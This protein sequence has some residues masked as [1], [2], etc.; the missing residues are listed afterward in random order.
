MSNE[1]RRV[2]LEDICEYIRNGANIK[3]SDNA[4]GTP[5][6][7]IETLSNGK[8]NRDRLGYA[9]IFDDK[10]SKYYLNNHD[11]L[12]SHI[13]SEKYLGRAVLYTKESKNEKIIHGM[14]L[15]SIRTCED[16]VVAPFLAYYFSTVNFKS[17]IAGISKKSVNQ[18]SFS[19]SALNKIHVPLPSIEKQREIAAILDKVSELVEKRK[20]Q[21]AELDRL[22]ESI[23]YDMFGDPVTNEKGWETE[24]FGDI[25]S[26]KA[27]DFVKAAAISEHR[28]V[29]L[30]PCY[31]GNGLRGFVQ[32]YTHNGT[33]VLIG[34]QGALCGNVKYVSG[35]FHAT[36]HAVVVTHKVEISAIW[37]YYCLYKL[38]LNR[39]ATGAAQPGLAVNKLNNISIILPPLPL[40]Q[41]FAEMIEKID[42]QKQK[43]K[44]AL[45]ESED[46]FQRLMQ[47]MFNPKYN[48]S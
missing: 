26:L 46:L 34:R 10:F 41:Q 37:L 36:E 32:T 43:V 27:G 18:A 23:F 4:E 9:N 21:L 7:R 3:Q 42:K 2:N 12:M 24:L 11:I 8:F 17:Q 15:L 16:M 5:I 20:A 14:N 47:D 45:K 38:N 40:Q 19:V 28:E 39:F 22:A 44:T 48:N 35:V 31:G 29:D 25:C 13:N 1:W 30:F 33:Y 6:T